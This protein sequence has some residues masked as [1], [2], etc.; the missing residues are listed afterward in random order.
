VLRELVAML[1]LAA[2]LW[3]VW[4]LGGLQVTLAQ[5]AD[6]PLQ[7]KLRTAEHIVHYRVDADGGPAFHLDGNELELRLITHL[8]LEP[9]RV[10]AAD[11]TYD[12]GLRLR[13]DAPTGETIW[14]RD[15]HTSTRQSKD[16]WNGSL[17]LRENAFGLEP[18]TEITDDRV[19]IITL[20]HE[21]PWGSQFH[22]RLEA[23]AAA[24]GLIRAYE[25]GQDASLGLAMAYF[26]P[27][28]AEEERLVGRLTY[29]PWDVLTQQQRAT[30]LELRWNRLSAVGD[31]DTNYEV[32]TLFYTGFRA[33]V[34]E[35]PP[36]PPVTLIDDRATALTAFGPGQ[37]TLW[38]HG[39]CS[40]RGPNDPL[41]SVDVVH[42]DAGGVV[43]E[44]DIDPCEGPSFEVW[45][46]E[47]PHTLHLRGHDLPETTIEAW[48]DDHHEA[49]LDLPGAELGRPFAPTITRSPRIRLH[50]GAAPADYALVEP[51]DLESAMLEL[52][53]QLPV[54]PRT[55][56]TAQRPAT[57]RLS[58]YDRHG[59]R[60]E[61]DEWRVEPLA[62]LEPYEWV[63]DAS[64]AE[65][66]WWVS[67]QRVARILAPEGTRRLRLEADGEVFVALFTYWPGTHASSLPLPPYDQHELVG[68]R[69]RRIPYDFLEWYLVDPHNTHVLQRH[70]QTVDIHG[71]V[72]LEPLAGGGA[73]G[74]GEAGQG[75]PDD[76]ETAGHEPLPTVS[77]W[78]SMAPY[79]EHERRT[80]L[81]RTPVGSRWA[82]YVRWRPG[83]ATLT[84]DD[85]WG[86]TL[87]YL[88]DGK[89]ERALGQEITVTI[90]GQALRTSI[91]STRDAWKL[92][93]LGPGTHVL[94]LGALPPGVRVYLD[95][96]QLR[97]DRGPAESYRV[98]TL[99]RLTGTT[100]G[101]AVDKTGDDRDYV[102]AIT[103]R[104]GE[105]EPSRIRVAL[106]EGVPRR[107][108]GKAV[109][110]VTSAVRERTLPARG[111]PSE[112]VFFDRPQERCETL[113]RIPIPM[114]PDVSEGHHRIELRVEDGPGL[115]VR[116]FRQG[117][118]DPEKARTHEWTERVIDL[119]EPAP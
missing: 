95:R 34:A 114:G 62:R 50:A 29:L 65:H 30:R 13:I 43:D 61:Q 40:A 8:V 104:C 47:G 48:Y 100:M 45:L 83:R 35:L 24:Y 20:P 12:Y 113:G 103:Y 84:V 77:S 72:R 55:D 68:T 119:Q 26:G 111:D 16:G 23:P 78:V 116:F 80:V 18:G 46:P 106:D 81:E 15:V 10:Y 42:V 27:A 14:Q 17:W 112:L 97:P 88:V 39:D 28:R 1:V 22:V 2:T 98:I 79:T 54:D 44:R 5:R 109:D 70:E 9:G 85:D 92:P 19:H 3:G 110:L 59:Q 57:V 36:P 75:D 7:H 31:L 60:L 4:R 89:P 71:P 76:G 38:I 118:A 107:Q 63:V 108:R 93:G 117:A 69:W 74:L 105:H 115:W 56:P 21:I 37:M 32:D 94:E 51:E 90:A 82:R 67:P 58:F 86:A 41:P 66:Q 64:N 52:R 6:S 96:P 33:P 91:V 101:L 73:G 53:A 11:R 49:S 25:R 87:V 99:H 102:N